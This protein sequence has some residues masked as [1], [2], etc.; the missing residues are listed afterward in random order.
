MARQLSFISCFDNEPTVWA[1][2][3]LKKTVVF[4]FVTTQPIYNSLY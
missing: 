3:N 2:R 4:I 1:G